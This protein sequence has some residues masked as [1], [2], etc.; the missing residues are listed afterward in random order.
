VTKDQFSDFMLVIGLDPQRVSEAERFFDYCHELVQSG[1][2]E[3]KTLN[4]KGV[5]VPKWW[6]MFEENQK[7]DRAKD[8]VKDDLADFI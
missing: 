3:G 5:I 4:E 6:K 7:G 1:G 8:D 2:T